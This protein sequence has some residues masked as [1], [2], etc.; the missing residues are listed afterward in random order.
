[1]MGSSTTPGG[2]RFPPP[3]PFKDVLVCSNLKSVTPIS[4]RIDLNKISTELLVSTRTRSNF[5]LAVVTLITKASS[6]GYRIPYSSSS[7]H[8]IE[9]CLILTRL[10]VGGVE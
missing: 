7:V 5:L 2:T 8:M 10:A 4:S 3:N 6:C 1:M 9:T